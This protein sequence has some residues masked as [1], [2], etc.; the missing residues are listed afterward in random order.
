MWRE[1]EVHHLSQLAKAGMGILMIRAMPEVI[2]MA[3]R[4]LVM[5]EGKLTAELS[6]PR[7]PRRQSCSQRPAN[8]IKTMTTDHRPFQR[9]LVGPF[10]PHERSV[11]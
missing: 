4:V 10:S 9:K 11:C 1:I 2:G 8:S 7:L 3:D 6:G 5:H